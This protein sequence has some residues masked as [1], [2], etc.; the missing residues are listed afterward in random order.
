MNNKQKVKAVD[1]NKYLHQEIDF[2]KIDIEG[3]E[4]HL[5]FHISEN[6]R[7]VKNLFIEYHGLKNQRQ[8]L[9]E[10]LNLLTNV[11][12]EYYIRVAGETIRFPFCNERPRVFNQQLNIMCYRIN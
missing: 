9:G 11:G 3:A 7:N 4:N 2:L 10:I 6:L 8:N 12:F 1:L 5:I